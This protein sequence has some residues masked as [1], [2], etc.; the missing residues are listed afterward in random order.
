M[1]KI[2]RTA[3]L[4]DSCVMKCMISEI[5]SGVVVECFM[6]LWKLEDGSENIFPWER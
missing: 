2:S 4:G 1:G 3:L 5:E 6:G